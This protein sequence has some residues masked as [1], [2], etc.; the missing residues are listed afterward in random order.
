MIRRPAPAI[1]RVSPQERPA[2]WS[3]VV[4]PFYERHLT[5]EE[6]GGKWTGLFDEAKND[7]SSDEVLDLA[8]RWLN[9]ADATTG[10]GSDLRAKHAAACREALADPEVAPKLPLSRGLLDWFAPALKKA[11]VLRGELI[12]ER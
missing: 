9:L 12:T 6:R 1:Q 4:R 10:G 3:D 11:A 2:S 7:A 5:A 8:V